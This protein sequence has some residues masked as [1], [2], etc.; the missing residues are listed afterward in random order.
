MTTSWGKD[1]QS[2]LVHFENVNYV[3]IKVYG[4]CIWAGTSIAFQYNRIL[5]ELKTSEVLMICQQPVL[6]YSL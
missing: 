6:V 3:V 2:F 1:F 4:F 5:S